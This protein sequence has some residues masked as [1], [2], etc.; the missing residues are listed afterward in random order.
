VEPGTYDLGHGSLSMKQHGDVQGAG[1][2]QTLITSD[3]NDSVPCDHGTLEGANDA[4]LRFLTVRNTGTV[5]QCHVAIHN[6]SASPRLTHVTAEATA[7]G[8]A[9]I[10]YG[11]YNVGSSPIVTDVTAMGSE[12]DSNYGVR[13]TSASSPI[14]TDV[15]A[16]ASGGTQSIGVRN[17]DDSSSTITQSK[18]SGNSYALYQRSGGTLRIALTQLVGPIDTDPNA[19][20]LQC[21]NNYDGSLGAVSCP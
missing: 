18:L 7:V 6:A 21:F 20:D 3:L 19:G 9:T 2:L 8:I 4:E 13:N 10:D 5:P 14:M 17:S 12:G 1:E 15:A 11:V 16:T